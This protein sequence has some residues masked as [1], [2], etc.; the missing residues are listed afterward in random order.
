MPGRR[1]TVRLSAKAPTVMQLRRPDFA[2]RPVTSTENGSAID[3][4]ALFWR[5]K[6]TLIGTVLAVTAFS[7][8][9]AFQITPRFT[10]SAR[11]LIAAVPTTSGGV[12]SL[13][14]AFGG[15]VR[16]QIYGEIEVMRS[17]RLIAAAVNELGLMSQPEFNPNLEPGPIRRFLAWQPVRTALRFIPSMDRDS[18]TEA[19][20]RARERQEV[21]EAFRRRLDIRPPGISNVVV[22]NFASV[23]AR[24]AAN[25][26]NTFIEI[27]TADQLDRQLRAQAESRSWLDKRIGQLREAMI[28]SERAVAEYLGSRRLVESGQSAVLDRQFADVS[29]QLS[30]AKAALAERQT[31]L[32]QV[33]RLRDSDQGLGA[34]REIRQSPLIQRLR[35]QEVSLMR[36]AAEL[37]SR[38]GER[39][40]RMVNL[41]AELSEARKRISDE[42]ARVVLELENEVRVAKARVTTL[43]DELDKIDEQRVDVGRDRIKLRQL[44]RD[45][46]SNQRLYEASLARLKQASADPAS[47]EQSSAEVIS[48]AQIPLDASYPRKGLIVGFGF[49]ISIA[50]GVLLVLIVERFDSGFRTQDQI[51]RLTDLPVLGIVPR[52][53]SAE[54]DGHAA[55][56]IVVSDPDSPYVEAIRSLRTSLMVTNVD[57]PAKIVAIAS[58]LPGEGKSSLAAAFAR[59]T[60][61]A[62]LNG[63]VILI[64]C[65]LRRP[66]LSGMLGLRAELGITELFSG[67]AGLDDVVRSD[68]KTGLH[69]LPAMPGTPNPPELLNSR[70]MRDLLDKLAQTY[71]MI[72]IDSPAVES[73]S[74]ARIIA[75]LADTTVFVVQ[76]ETTPRE[77]A[78]GALRQ[79][80]SAGAEIAGVVLHCANLRRQQKYGV[81]ELRAA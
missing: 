25:I 9:A 52:L 49:L 31:R 24:R 80:A 81:E 37:G 77:T 48:P 57:R 23:D 32:E 8:V 7:V 53:A 27:Y 11:L 78:I 16:T 18:L 63:R 42:E 12:A 74:D 34:I 65:D 22:V 64:D 55:A 50:F 68:P 60:A 2:P 19:E 47:F 66:S 58:A 33:Y 40:P 6:S 72:V 75:H 56:D 41:R 69:V 10:A 76:S 20:K 5:R 43:A 70:H 13:S 1:G 15:A 30:E 3:L 26:V 71:D 51:E 39:H 17:E 14:Q 28:E 29:Q 36:E 54:K 4:L 61:L 38:F 45:A 21:Y 62:T 79:L 67:E 73:V 35:E 46:E 44:Q 59:H